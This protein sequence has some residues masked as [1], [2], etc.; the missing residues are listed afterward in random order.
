MGEFTLAVRLGQPPVMARELLRLHRQIY[1]V[2]WRWSESAVNHAM[3]HGC[4]V[5]TIQGAEPN[6]KAAMN[7]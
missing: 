6:G 5:V 2:F 7:R 4:P 1:L 3:L